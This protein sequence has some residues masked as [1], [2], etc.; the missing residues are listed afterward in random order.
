MIKPKL[1]NFYPNSLNS[2]NI[3]NNSS[4]FSS[5]FTVEYTAEIYYIGFIFMVFPATWLI[6]KITLR[7]TILLGSFLNCFGSLIKSLGYGNWNWVILGQ[8][9][10]A[11]TQCLIL[12]LP[13]KISFELFEEGTRNRTTSIGVFGN[14]VGVALG[15][16]LPIILFNNLALTVTLLYMLILVEHFFTD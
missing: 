16:L 1:L 3:E 2:S 8:T 15:F 12:P 14:Q 7:Q 4:S 11:L 5:F 13:P 6:N 10:V 9:I